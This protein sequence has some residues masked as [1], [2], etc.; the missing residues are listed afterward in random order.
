MNK[1]ILVVVW[2]FLIINKSASA[3]TFNVAH[4]TLK[5]SVFGANVTVPDAHSDITNNS[6]KKIT[7]SWTVTT[8]ITTL[9]DWY[10]SICDNKNCYT[11][12]PGGTV[13]YSDTIQPGSTGS[14]KVG[15]AYGAMPQNVKGE[16]IVT[17]TSGATVKTVYFSFN[18]PSAP[19]GVKNYFN[20]PSKTINVFPNPA[21][22]V[23]HVGF[24]AFENIEFIYVYNAIGSKVKTIETDSDLKSK[25]ILVKNIP[26]GVYFIQLAD[27]NNK[28]VASR[29]FFKK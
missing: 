14:F 9:S 2:A 17:M 26:N 3:Q 22:D 25:D 23:L 5:S 29:Q 11:A 20:S 15:V 13:Y 12:F 18:D 8:N 28:I 16:V 19:L 27:N 24:S 10:L 1:I 6:S 21:T 4:D 7:V